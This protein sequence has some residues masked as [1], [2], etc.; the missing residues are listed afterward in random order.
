MRCMAYFN[1]SLYMT[2]LLR[3]YILSYDTKKR[4]L[5]EYKKVWCREMNISPYTSYTIQIRDFL[6]KEKFKEDHH[7]PQR[8]HLQET[9]EQ[10]GQ[11]CCDELFPQHED[12]LH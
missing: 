11:S 5:R 4:K 1:F 2:H 8:L 6:E 12:V 9:A 3:K 10:E 7:P